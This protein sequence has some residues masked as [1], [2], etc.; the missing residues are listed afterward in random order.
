MAR[1]HSNSNESIASDIAIEENDKDELIETRR[2]AFGSPTWSAK[3]DELLRYLK[4]VEKI[5][6]RDISM[7]FPSRTINACQFRWRRLILKEENRKKREDRKNK[8]REK[9]ANGDLD[10]GSEIEKQEKAEEV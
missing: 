8:I 10:L 6:W 3:D 2:M 7:Y 1:V 4:E 9:L 5:G